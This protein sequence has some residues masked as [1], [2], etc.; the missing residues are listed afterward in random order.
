MKKKKMTKAKEIALSNYLKERNNLKRRLKY[1]EKNYGE[2][3][4]IDLLTKKEASLLKT[5]ELKKKTKELSKIN[6][7]SITKKE[8]KDVEW[9]ELY[10]KDQ[11]VIH[12]FYKGM[13]AIIENQYGISDDEQSQ[14]AAFMVWFSNQSLSKQL[15]ILKTLDSQS[16]HTAW[17]NVYSS[18]SKIK[19]DARATAEFRVNW[20]EQLFKSGRIHGFRRNSSL[21]KQLDKMDGY[22]MWSKVNKSVYTKYKSGKKFWEEY[23]TKSLDELDFIASWDKEKAIF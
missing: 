21:E 4:R 18:G 7:K 22:E 9:T 5:T 15:Q 19:G 12:N 1:A 8:Y 6:F 16:D 3:L 17:I 11:Q 14:L 10:R 23:P 13:Q 20:V 2:T